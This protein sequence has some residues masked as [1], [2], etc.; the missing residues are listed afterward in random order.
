VRAN[1]SSGTMRTALR[2]DSDCLRYEKLPCIPRICARARF[3]CLCT[4]S[5]SLPRNHI[6]PPLALSLSRARV[7]RCL[8]HCPFALP[9]LSLY[10]HI[11]IGLSLLLQM[12]KR[13]TTRS[14]SLSLA[15]LSLLASLSFRIFLRFLR[16]IFFQDTFHLVPSSRW[17]NFLSDFSFL[18]ASA[19]LGLVTRSLSLSLPLG[20]NERSFSFVCSSE[21]A[22]YVARVVRK[23]T[24]SGFSGG[25]PR[26]SIGDFARS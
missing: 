12:I 8:I 2:R 9:S 21:Q 20:R 17:K 1:S 3:I 16:Y 5:H 23:R 15:L 22:N 4:P 18:F 24:S 11:L 6:A 10:Q 7:P 26:E 19:S 14:L 25:D 13:T